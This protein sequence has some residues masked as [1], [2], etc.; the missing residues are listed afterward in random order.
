[1]EG[2]SYHTAFLMDNWLIPQNCDSIPVCRKIF[3]LVAKGPRNPGTPP[4]EGT[5]PQSRVSPCSLE[6]LQTIYYGGGECNQF[7]F[8][9]CI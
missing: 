3:L 8:T 9:S 4:L 2:F 5:T 6:D 1:M 7:S